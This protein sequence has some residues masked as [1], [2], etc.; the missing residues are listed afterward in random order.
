MKKLMAMLLA[1]SMTLSLAACGGN[2]DSSD[3]GNN[4]ASNGGS[5]S[6]YTTDSLLV[7]I[8]DSN[9]LDGLQKIADKWTEKSGV[10]VKIE[11]ISWDSYW[12]LLEAG[13]SGGELPDVFWMHI[14]E[15]QKYM[16]AN[17]LLDLNDYIANDASIDMNNYYEG[18]VDLYNLDGHQ[19]ALPK[20]HDTIAMLYNRGWTAKE[21]A[22]YMNLSP[23][24]ITNTIQVIYQKL[25]ISSKR[26]LGQFMLA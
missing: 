7:N 4:N 19:F 15:A 22:A 6:G 20:D 25:G 5:E 1:A 16:E 8:W 13:A 26:E 17:V 18:I 3:N 21:I 2:S 23:R 14:N 9:Q 10:K 11:V 24:T 12:T